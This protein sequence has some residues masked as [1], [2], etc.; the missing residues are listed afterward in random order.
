MGLI[1]G[2]Q[3]GS[4]PERKLRHQEPW[5]T[6][7]LNRDQ[8]LRGS[9]QYQWYADDL[10]VACGRLGGGAAHTQSPGTACCTGP[11]KQHLM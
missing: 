10:G 7:S 3:K 11:G 5:E 2:E 4:H 6:W 1:L 9:Q 8:D